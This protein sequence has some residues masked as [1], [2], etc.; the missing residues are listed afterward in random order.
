VK[1]GALPPKDVKIIFSAAS[2]PRNI[3]LSIFGESAPWTSREHEM[4]PNL[5]SLLHTHVWYKKFETAGH[6]GR[7]KYLVRVLH[8]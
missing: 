5:L 7:G 6:T 8:C 4:W 2:I 1:I 3:V